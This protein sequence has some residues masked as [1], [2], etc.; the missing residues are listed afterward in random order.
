MGDVPAYQ[1]ALQK[2]RDKHWINRGSIFN[3]RVG[4]GTGAA[5]FFVDIIADKGRIYSIRSTGKIDG[6]YI[7][8]ADGVL[9]VR[10]HNWNTA[11]AAGQQV[12]LEKNLDVSVIE[13]SSGD[14]DTGSVQ[15]VG[16][17][18]GD[19]ALGL[20]ADGYEVTLA[21][22]RNQGAVYLVETKGEF[23]GTVRCT[24]LIDAGDQRPEYR[25]SRGRSGLIVWDGLQARNE[26][27]ASSPS[28]DVG[29]LAHNVCIL[30]P[31]LH[32][33]NI[34]WQFKGSMVAFGARRYADQTV[35]LPILQ[36]VVI[37]G[38]NTAISG[39]SVYSLHIGDNAGDDNGQG[40]SPQVY[41]GMVPGFVGGF[42]PPLNLNPA[43][44]APG[45]E[46]TLQPMV[47]DPRVNVNGAVN[48][49]GDS[50]P[51]GPTAVSH[52]HPLLWDHDRW[53]WSHP[54]RGGGFPDEYGLDG[55]ALD[56]VIRAEVSLPPKSQV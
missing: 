25:D 29:H 45:E 28:L 20:P 44:P 23:R 32:E 8:A 42:R 14:G 17:F 13:A 54:K 36:R 22:A 35:A 33:I 43:E 26:V 31:S 30:A 37:P 46:T 56:S 49:N 7:K 38:D 34:G 40:Q 21:K 41:F 10:I 6:N 48:A 24:N 11:L 12:A 53:L 51:D 27:P 3:V 9:E 4:P 39:G 19:A 16:N 50:V 1:I 2:W 55:G 18:A 47:A 15:K 5:G 52:F